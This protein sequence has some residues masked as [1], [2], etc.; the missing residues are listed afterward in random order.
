MVTGEVVVLCDHLRALLE[1]GVASDCFDGTLRG[2]A[3]GE[4]VQVLKLGLICTSD[5]PSRRP[6]MAEVVQVLELIQP[7]TQP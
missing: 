2:V 3:E 7:G 1:Q 4:L 6:S 5:A